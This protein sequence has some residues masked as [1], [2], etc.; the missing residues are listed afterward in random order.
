ML[1]RKAQ[2]L[3]PVTPAM[4]EQYKETRRA[5]V[6]DNPE[7]LRS[8]EETLGKLPPFRD[9]LPAY[10]RMRT[11]HDG[12]LWVQDYNLAVDT[13]VT[14]SVFD[15]EGRWVTSVTMPRVWLVTDIGR[16]HI[17]TV[18][19]DSLD[20]ERVRMYPLRRTRN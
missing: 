8:V 17:L 18:E 16:N 11:D 1:I 10:R 14:W 7:R 9:S 4:I 19:T 13:N 12:M 3:R 5:A 15:L 20:V 6:G 2:P